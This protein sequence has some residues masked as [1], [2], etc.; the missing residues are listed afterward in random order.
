MSHNS[1]KVGAGAP[2]RQSEIE[3]DLD[4]LTDVS[5]TSPSSGDI[6]AWNGAAWAAS[7]V[8]A[9][10]AELMFIGEGSSQAYS[11]SGA[12]NPAAG[13]DA[14]FYD[15][16]PINGITGATIT[17]SGSWVS[18]VTLPAGTYMIEA[19]V[20]LTFST[21]S[22]ATFDFHDGS[23]YFGLDSFFGSTDFETGIVNRSTQTFAGSTTITVRVKSGSNLNT[24]AAQGTRQAERSFLSILKTA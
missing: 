3:L 11:G 8:A 14:Y 18:A 7:A 24:T 21:T 20:A 16:S 6:L 22:S 17:S 5:A 9:G 2:N 23:A 12:T 1:I 10:G 4:D 15:S 13:V 19:A